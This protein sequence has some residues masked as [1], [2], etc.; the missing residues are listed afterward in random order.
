LFEQKLAELNASD[1][2]INTDFERID[3]RSFAASV[4]LDG[5]RVG[6]V[7]IRHGSDMWRNALCLSYDSATSSRNSMNDCQPA[8]DV[9]PLSAPNIDPA[10]AILMMEL[11]NVVLGVRRRRAKPG[12]DAHPCRC[13]LFVDQAASR[14]LNRQ[15]SVRFK[16][17]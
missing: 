3:S 6:Q 2:R 16:S 13:H 17:A 15:I 10:M 1:Q 11:R 5:K 12:A 14:L 4:Y 7:S 8:R 9:E